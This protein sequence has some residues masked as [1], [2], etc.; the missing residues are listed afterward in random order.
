M[1]AFADYGFHEVPVFPDLPSSTD[2]QYEEEFMEPPSTS[3]TSSSSSGSNGLDVVCTKNG[4]QITLQTG[5]LSDVRVLGK[6]VDF[7]TI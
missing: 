6:Y 4:F 2:D 1:D 5:Q 7:L 3:W